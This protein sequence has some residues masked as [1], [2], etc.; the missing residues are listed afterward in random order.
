MMKL[1]I[2][3]LLSLISF[4]ILSSFGCA[5]NEQAFNSKLYVDYVG[6]LTPQFQAKIALAITKINTDAGGE[7]ISFTKNDT[8]LRPLVF[9]NLSSTDIFAHTQPLDY[10]CLISIDETNF[11]VNSNDPD[12]ID[13]RVVLLHEIGHCYNLNHSSNSSDIMYASY[14]GTPYMT[15][16][17]ITLLMSKMTTFAQALLNMLP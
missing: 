1:K 8:H 11:I 12:V 5:K 10:R 4:V 3:F 14:P 17:Q 6:E 7:L 2:T 16:P 9:S 15:N 13:L